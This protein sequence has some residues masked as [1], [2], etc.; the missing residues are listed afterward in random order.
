M[1]DGG[2]AELE[3]E[4]GV[5]PTTSSTKRPS[6]HEVRRP[7]HGNRNQTHQE[8]TERYAED[9][10]VLW[11]QELR[12]PV[13]GEADNPVEERADDTDSTLDYAEDAEPNCER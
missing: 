9:K 4:K 2:K 5:D 12:V 13:K 10:H 7:G 3:D 6:L 11:G 1:R 8:I